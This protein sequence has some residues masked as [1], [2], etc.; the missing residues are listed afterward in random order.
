MDE[1]D[2]IL[3]PMKSE[4]NFPIGKAL[5]MLLQHKEIETISD[6]PENTHG[7]VYRITHK[8][9]GK[10]YIG[11][12]VL[13]YERNKRLGKKELI[14]LKEER[15]GIPGRLPTKK[16]VITES[17]WPVYWGSNKPLLKLVKSYNL[18][19]CI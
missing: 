12:K 10:T 11:K 16:K 8:P 1:V 17:N 3:H 15:K 6:F 13:Y 7:F 14:I 18:I 4:L 9:S 19:W 5:S 2:L